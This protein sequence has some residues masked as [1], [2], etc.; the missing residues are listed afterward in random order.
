MI[1]VEG[2][3]VL[4]LIHRAVVRH[5]RPDECEAGDAVEV[6]SGDGVEGEVGVETVGKYQDEREIGGRVCG[7]AAGEG[8]YGTEYG[9]AST[10]EYGAAGTDR[11][12]HEVTPTPRPCPRC[13]PHS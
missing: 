2:G 8:G 3:A 5:Y 11:G 6:E 7:K 4:A 12:W 10:N 9:T 13:G 1:E